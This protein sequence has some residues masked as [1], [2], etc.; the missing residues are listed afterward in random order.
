M[1]CIYSS[2]AGKGWN[3]G[4]AA[5]GNPAPS[6][7]YYLAEG[8]TIINFDTWY[9]LAGPREDK[10]C[11]VVIEEVFGDGS[12]HSAEYWTNPHSRLTVN[13]NDAVSRQA[14][15]SSLITPSFPIIV[16]RPMY[17]NYHGAIT[18]GHNVN[19]YGVDRQPPDCPFVAS[20]DLAS[21]RP[22]Q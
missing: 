12:V 3:G 22:P 15:V 18:G 6:T 11:K 16:E 21:T 5:L 17:S 2:D 13:V 1:Y 10:G 19:G 4:E 7:Q 20:D 14:D 8:T 9:T